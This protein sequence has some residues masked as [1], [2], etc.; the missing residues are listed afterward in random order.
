MRPES[1]VFLT[2]MFLRKKEQKYYANAEKIE[3]KWTENSEEGAFF[4]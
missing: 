3:R 4:M 2:K 1:T